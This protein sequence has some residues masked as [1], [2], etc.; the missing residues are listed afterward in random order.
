MNKTTTRA[1][2]FDVLCAQRRQG[3]VPM[4]ERYPIGIRNKRE[5]RAE[6]AGSLI[7]AAILIGI[8]FG[9]PAL[10][11]ALARVFL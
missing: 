8:C 7:G 10:V 11:H 9:V 3:P 1:P 6:L 2:S 5:E 4:R